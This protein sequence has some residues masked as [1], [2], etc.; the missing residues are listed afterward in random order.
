MRRRS[1][2][3]GHIVHA[4]VEPDEVGTLAVK[5]VYDHVTAEFVELNVATCGDCVTVVR[6]K[7]VAKV[8]PSVLGQVGLYYSVNKWN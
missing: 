5:R 2:K 3:L 4:H 6:G 8:F 1:E 7:L